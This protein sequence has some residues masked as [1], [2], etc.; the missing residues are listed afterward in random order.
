MFPPKTQ[1]EK[2]LP[3]LFPLSTAVLSLYENLLVAELIDSREKSSR[4]RKRK[5]EK[6]IFLLLV[7]YCSMD[8]YYSNVF[9]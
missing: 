6:N 8:F 9:I 1:W 5:K 3:N 2:F 4:L 7:I